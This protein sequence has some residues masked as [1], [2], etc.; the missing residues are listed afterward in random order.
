ME[1]QK[2]EENRYKMKVKCGIGREKRG[3]IGK[4]RKKYFISKRIG[5]LFANHSFVKKVQTRKEIV[6]TPFEQAKE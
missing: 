5:T 1:G 2:E 4:K 6:V 3:R